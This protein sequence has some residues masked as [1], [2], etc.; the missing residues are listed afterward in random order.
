MVKPEPD[1]NDVLREE[2][3][4]FDFSGKVALVTGASGNLGKAVASAFQNVGA[5]VGII[6]R[7]AGILNRSFR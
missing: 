4:M 3:I 7:S 2:L 1:H 5:K 6:G